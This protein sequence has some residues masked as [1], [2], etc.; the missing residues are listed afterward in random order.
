MWSLCGSNA[1]PLDLQSSALPTA[2]KNPNVSSLADLRSRQCAPLG[3]SLR[4]PHLL[5]WFPFNGDTKTRFPAPHSSL[6]FAGHRSRSPVTVT[7]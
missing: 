1:R 7:G 5:E 2:P 6:V 4:A 3:A